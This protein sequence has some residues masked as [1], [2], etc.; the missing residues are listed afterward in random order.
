[1]GKLF[2]RLSVVFIAVYLLFVFI[3]FYI[4]G[5]NYWSQSYFLLVELCVCACMTAKWKYHCEYLRWTMY[6]ITLAEIMININNTFGIYGDYEYYAL[7]GVPAFCIGMGV[8]LS[9]VFATFDYLKNR[10][11]KREQGP[12]GVNGESSSAGNGLDGK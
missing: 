8:L 10:R 11:Q 4:H 6:G 1:M 12:A 9:I 3:G 5:E 2:I 7:G